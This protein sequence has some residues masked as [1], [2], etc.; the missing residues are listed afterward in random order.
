MMLSDDMFD[1]FLANG[2]PTLADC[3]LIRC[4]FCLLACNTIK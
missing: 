3:L 4:R 1:A 2:N